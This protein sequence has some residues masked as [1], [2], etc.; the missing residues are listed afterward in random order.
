MAGYAGRRGAREHD[1][2]KVIEL[3]RTQRVYV[4]EKA[5]DWVE[6]EDIGS[7]SVIFEG[8]PS[9]ACRFLQARENQR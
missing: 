6:L 1:V 2:G 5:P 9:V 4:H 7:R 8:K 3:A